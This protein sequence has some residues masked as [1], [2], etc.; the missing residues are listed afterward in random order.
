MNSTV[1]IYQLVSHIPD[2]LRNIVLMK[3]QR[4][5]Y[6]FMSG[7]NYLSVINITDVLSAGNGTHTQTKRD[8]L[9]VIIAQKS[10]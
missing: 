2:I 6:M 5:R 3:L 10:A 8:V 4:L 9:Y 1:L 7:N